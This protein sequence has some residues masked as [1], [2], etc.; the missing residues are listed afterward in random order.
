MGYD[1]ATSQ[2]TSINMKFSM[3]S[4]STALAINFGMNTLENLQQVKGDNDRVTLLTKMVKFG[5][6]TQAIADATSS[7]Y[8]AFYP[9]ATIVYCTNWALVDTKY[10]HLASCFVRVGNTLMYPLVVSS[11]YNHDEGTMPN[12]CTKKAVDSKTKATA[13]AA[14]YYCNLMNFNIGFVYYPAADLSSNPT[15]SPTPY[16]PGTPTMKPTTF[17]PTKRPT[18]S[19]NFIPYIPG[20]PTFKPTLGAPTPIPTSFSP[21]LKPTTL[22]PT[23]SPTRKPTTSPTPINTKKPTKAPSNRRVLDNMLSI[24]NMEHNR[25]T[26][27]ENALAV[28]FQYYNTSS[29]TGSMGYTLFLQNKCSDHFMYNCTYDTT[30][31]SYTVFEKEYKTNVCGGNPH[32]VQSPTNMCKRYIM[33]VLINVLI[34]TLNDSGGLS[35]SQ[36][37]ICTTDYILPSSTS[38]T[39]DYNFQTIIIIIIIII[40]I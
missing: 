39:Y 38:G 9:P 12:R 40:I 36:M 14:G 24:N 6:I 33:I 31:Q 3:I 22:Y 37:P 13:D 8:D 35:Q 19:P 17:P 26:T 16:T 23:K 15:A 27:S 5:Y 21:T 34:L 11:G 20:T 32:V 18:K 4:V 10:K 7:Y 29:C 2:T 28:V 25:S 1:T 30:T